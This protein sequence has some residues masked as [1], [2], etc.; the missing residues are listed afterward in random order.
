MDYE[1]T[2]GRAA[3]KTLEGPYENPLRFRFFDPSQ[4]QRAPQNKSRV[5]NLVIFSYFACFGWLFFK[6]RSFFGNTE[7][8]T[9]RRG[10]LTPSLKQNSGKGFPHE[11]TRK[12]FSVTQSSL[13]W[14]LYMCNSEYTSWKCSAYTSWK[15]S[16]SWNAAA[17]RS[18][19]PINYERPTRNR[20]SPLPPSPKRLR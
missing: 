14:E 20:Y 9:P 11:P 19:L 6:T 17:W 13:V 16:N 3:K 4:F 1:V 18:K 8:S 2:I 10:F 12:P 5:P 15:C 7:I